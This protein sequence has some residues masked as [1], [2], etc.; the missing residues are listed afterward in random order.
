MDEAVHSDVVDVAFSVRGEAVD[1]DYAYALLQAVSRVL[2]WIA[3]EPRAGI[4]PLKGATASGERLVL[5]R[6]AQLVLRLPRER[7]AEASALRGSRF[8]L[9]GQVEVGEAAVRELTPYPVLYSHFVSMG[10]DAE[11]DFVLEAARLVT[12]ARIEC[13]LIVGKRRQARSGEGRVSGYSLMLHGLSA[14]HSLQAQG[15]GLGGNRMLGCGIFV[16]HKSI[17]PVGA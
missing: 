10:I 17:A 4:H 3:H 7:V 11:E 5:A 8:D 16:P 6:R 15:A 1:P 14:A 13:K 12:A 2:A 9:G